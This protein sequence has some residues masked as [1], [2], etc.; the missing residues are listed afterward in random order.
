VRI[1]AE[2]TVSADGLTKAMLHAGQIVATGAVAP[3]RNAFAAWPRYP[4][5]AARISTAG[6]RLAWRR[7]N[8]SRK[9]GTGAG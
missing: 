1:G 8:E 6:Y 3:G 9:T 4:R 2:T 7:E 5:I